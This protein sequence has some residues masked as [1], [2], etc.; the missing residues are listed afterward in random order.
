MDAYLD[1]ASAAVTEMGGKVAKKL[2]VRT[3][4]AIRLSCGSGEQFRARRASGAC[5]ASGAHRTE[6][7]QRLG[8]P[9]LAARIA[10]DSG[11]VVIDAAGRILGEVPNIVAQAQALAEPG[12]VVVTARVQRQV[13]GLFVANERGSHQLK[14]VPEAVTLYRIVRATGGEHPRPNYYRLIARAVNRT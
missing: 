13:A 2:S 11:P 12:A 6:S 3:D 4:G 5:N 8:R 14:G 10:I 9:A 1:A 7:N